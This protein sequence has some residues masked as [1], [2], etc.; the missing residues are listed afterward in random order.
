MAPIEGVTPVEK[1][2]VSRL[3]LG[4]GWDIAEMNLV[5]Q[6]LS[7]LKGGGLARAAA[8]GRVEA[9]ILSDVVGDDPAT[10][11][12]GPTVPPLGGPAEAM[13]L[14]RA[15][16][17]WERMPA[18]CHAALG[19][20][21]EPVPK[22]GWRLVGSNRLSVDA[23]AAVA[24]SGRV[25]AAPLVGDVAEAAA[26]VAEAARRGEGTT[27]WGGETTVVLRGDGRGGRNQELALRVARALMGFERRWTFLS[28]GTDG[29]DGPV[30]AAGAVVDQGTLGRIAAAGLDLNEMLA[31]NDSYPT[32]AAAGDLLMTG[33]TGT[34]VADLQVLRVE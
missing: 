32:L 9:L 5:R 16:G 7:R 13:A 10:V 3:L 31:R 6:N 15:R 34:N 24:P 18:S 23:M 26:R 17:L 30:D 4:A 12:S 14:L 27:L 25:E 21:P 29:R 19:R 1:A 2:E 11:A 8:P 28:G 20:S 22:A 33:T